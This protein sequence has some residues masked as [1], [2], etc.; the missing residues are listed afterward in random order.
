MIY[1]SQIVKLVLL[2]AIYLVIS[3]D[4]LPC[5]FINNEIKCENFN[6]FSELT[7]DNVND[8]VKSISLKPNIPILLDDSLDLSRLNFA[9]EY[10]AQLENIKGFS[11]FSN[12]FANGK[13]VKGNFYLNNSVFDFYKDGQKIDSKTCDYINRNEIYISL[14]DVFDLVSLEEGVTYP[15]EFCPCEFKHVNLQVFEVFNMNRNNRLHFM[16]I[17]I[18]DSNSDLNCTVKDLQVYSSEIDLD[19]N[20]FYPEVFKNLQSLFVQL[21]TVNSVGENFF[22]N[23]Q[24]LRLIRLSIYNFRELFNKDTKWMKSLNYPISVNLSDP[25]EVSRNN[26][27]QMIIEL[28][29]LNNQYD[30]PEKDFC[31]FES[32]PHEN[33]VFPAIETKANL[34]CTCTLMWLLK[35]KNLFA[36]D[37][38][39]LNTKSVSNCNFNSFSDLTFENVNSV[40]KSISLKPAMPLLLDQALDLTGLNFTAEYIVNLENIKGFQFYSNPFANIGKIKGDLY[41]KNSVFDFYKDDQRIDIKTCDYI[42]RNEFYVSLFDVFDLVSLGEGVIYPDEFC[43]CEFKNVEMGTFEIF[44]INNN[45]KLNFMQIPIND[46]DSDLKCSIKD[47]QIYSSEIDLNTNYIYPEVFRRLQSMFVQLSTVNNIE[48]TFFKNFRELRLIKLGINNFRQLFNKDTKWLRNLN[49]PIKVNLSDPGEVNRNREN[50][51]I[52]ELNDF[53][54]QYD[55]PEKDFC[56]FESFPHEHLVFPV[57]EAKENLECTCTLM[58]LIKN[59]N[60][61]A[62]D[63]RLLDTKSVSNCLNSKKFDSIISDC[64]FNKKKEKCNNAQVSTN[65]FETLFIIFVILWVIS[66]IALG[67]TIFV[68][69]RFKKADPNFSIGFSPKTFENFKLDLR[70]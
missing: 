69:F 11:F 13:L 36:K 47:L 31:F 27:N 55:F 41:L 1:S 12:P 2:I 62:R 32:F 30:F 70:K 28:K 61:F 45:N 50:Q 9:T 59:K 22:A 3:Y 51:M 10:I 43:P 14:F 64:D 16:K 8:E 56:F 63:I 53:N 65:S 46:S 26:G 18:N 15:D 35:N 57:I 4:C 44:N 17:P 21:S 20:Y 66:T 23:F 40:V 49:F 48:E 67:F 37:I 34:D 42:N 60:L 6:S 39:L 29:D 25:E 58:W 68:I 52:I 33:L 38:Q 19:K 5:S 54:K 7:F 24:Q